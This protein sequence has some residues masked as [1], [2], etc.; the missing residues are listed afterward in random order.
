MPADPAPMPS[1]GRLL[2]SLV[3][4]LWLNSPLSVFS[5][6]ASAVTVTDSVL[7]PTSSAMSMRT[8]CATWTVIPC[9][10]N[11][12]NPGSATDTSYVPAGIWASV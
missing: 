10:T 2:R 4:M 11:F 8:V 3:L 7:A 9:R 12:L 1:T 5:S 6:G